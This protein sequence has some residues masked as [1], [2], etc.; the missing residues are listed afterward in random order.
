[1]VAAYLGQQVSQERLAKLLGTRDFGT[2]ASRIR[3]LTR[4]DFSVT[5]ESGS[6]ELLRHWL[7]VGVPCIAFVWTGGLPYWHL[8]TPHAVVVVGAT[9]EAVFVNNPVFDVAP[10]Q[11]PI[12]DFVRAWSEFDYRYATLTRLSSEKKE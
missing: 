8:S 9:G 1:M 11:I 6:L 10:Q 12:G 4:L 7:R 3:L 5:Y 2:P